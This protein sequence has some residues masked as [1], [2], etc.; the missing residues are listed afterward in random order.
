MKP[1][2]RT[3]I[4]LFGGAAILVLAVGCGVGT[5]S[6]SS[7]TTTT[8]TTSTSVTPPPPTTDHE[9]PPSAP[10]GCVPHLNC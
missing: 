8:T 4:T 6:I 1:Q 5:K 9:V 3:A 2:A 7:T 10:S